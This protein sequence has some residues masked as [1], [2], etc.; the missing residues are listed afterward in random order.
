MDFNSNKENDI[1]S[2]NKF[3]NNGNNN[4]PVLEKKFTKKIGD[5]FSTKFDLDDDDPFGKKIDFKTNGLENENN[6]K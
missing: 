4:N 1:L 5:P 2:D 6:K 3:G